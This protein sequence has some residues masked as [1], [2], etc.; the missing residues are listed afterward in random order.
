MLSQMFYVS[1]SVTALVIE[2]LKCGKANEELNSDVYLF[3]LYL[4]V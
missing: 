3:K 4:N 1:S 2:L